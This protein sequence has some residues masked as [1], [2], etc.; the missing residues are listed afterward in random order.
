MNLQLINV[1]LC[2]AKLLRSTRYFNTLDGRDIADLIY[3]NTMVTYMLSQDSKQAEF[4]RKYA[5]D[6]Q[7]YGTYSLFRTHAT[8]LYLLMYTALHPNNDHV[9]LRDASDS[10]KFLSDL[11]L[12]KLYHKRFMQNI[13]SESATPSEA[14][15]YLYRL[16]NQLRI[17][18]SRYK[19]WRRIALRWDKLK[20]SE[21]QS[22][23]AQ[24]TQ[25]LRR[26]GNGTAT[27]SEIGKPL[28]SMLKQR[29]MRNKDKPSSNTGKKLAGAALG[30][31]AGRYAADK[32]NKTN[33]NTA[34]NVGTGIGAI[35]GYW[36][37]S[38]DKK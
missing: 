2:E 22:I 1:E 10:K 30:A 17:K 15:T 21:K 27:N 7:Q 28:Q 13:A 14:N 26:K 20:Y 24:I 38:R 31:V 23:V 8:D 9:K 33:N 6:T 18:D 4:A 5:A 35:A 34:K 32:L 11:T 19:S 37:A 29:I 3:L 25:E 16:E 12:N 36:A